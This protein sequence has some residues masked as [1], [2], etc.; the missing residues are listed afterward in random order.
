M[1]VGQKAARERAE[2]GDWLVQD[3]NEDLLFDTPKQV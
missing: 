1:Q 2:N 3:A